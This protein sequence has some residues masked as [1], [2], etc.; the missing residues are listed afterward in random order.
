MKFAPNGSKCVTNQNDACH[1]CRYVKCQVPVGCTNL[2]IKSEERRKR[3]AV[4]SRTKPDCLSVRYNKSD[5]DNSACLQELRIVDYTE[6][7]SLLLNSNPIRKK[8]VSINTLR[9][10]D[11]RR[12]SALLRTI[13]MSIEPCSYPDKFS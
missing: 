9:I 13:I 12:A 6:I 3:L 2:E 5:G 10:F 1:Q 4:G 11:R 8:H 7:C